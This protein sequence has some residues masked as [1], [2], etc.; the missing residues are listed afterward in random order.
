NPIVIADLAIGQV[1]TNA[2]FGYQN[3]SGQIMGNV[4]HDRN[5]DG[6]PTSD[7]VGI[8][9]VTTDLIRDINGNGVLDL[10]ENI[11]ATDTTDVNGFFE[12]TGLTAGD[13]LLR[14]NDSQ[15]TLQISSGSVHFASGQSNPMPVELQ[16]GQ[17]SNN[18]HFLYQSQ[19]SRR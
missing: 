7:D 3:Q 15:G 4:W 5:R 14:A 8:P 13:Y 12:F 18:H 6:Q 19:V 10:G 2:N 1:H 16:A 9:N 11:L 17:T